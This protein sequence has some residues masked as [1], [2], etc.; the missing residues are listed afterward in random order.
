MGVAGPGMQSTERPDVDHAAA[1]GSQIRQ[2]FA[3]HQ[4]R[5]AGVGFKGRVPLLDGEAL[6]RTR[7]EDGGVIDDEIEMAELGQNGGH[8]GAN[9]KLGA[10]VALDSDC[11][12]AKCGNLGG[13]FSGFGARGAVGDGDVGSSF[14]K[15]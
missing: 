11:A 12:A 8:G 4:K 5:T 15:R 6:K 3:R 1:R 2:G 9:R 10:D 13:S 14:G 7:G